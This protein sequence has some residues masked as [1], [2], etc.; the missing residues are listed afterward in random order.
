VEI[1]ALGLDLSVA[2]ADP[3]FTGAFTSTLSGT[4]ARIATGTTV[5][6][7]ADTLTGSGALGTDLTG[8]TW[9]EVGSFTRGAT[10]TNADTSVSSVTAAVVDVGEPGGIVACSARRG[11]S[12]GRSVGLILAWIDDQNYIRVRWD[13]ASGG[14]HLAIQEIVAGVATTIAAGTATAPWS[15]AARQTNPWVRVVAGI[16]TNGTNRF[17][18]ANA[19]DRNPISTVATS[20][21]SIFDVATKVGFDLV[22]GI[23]TTDLF[24]DFIVTRG[25]QP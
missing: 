17:I 15:L 12:T 8:K 5:L 11:T 18:T 21:N 24:R 7:A 4:F 2:A 23:S 1:G 3:A 14:A 22:G 20:F 10:A 19:I 9:S 6:L 16:S 25:L 13:I